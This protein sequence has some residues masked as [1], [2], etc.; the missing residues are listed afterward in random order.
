MEV[1][2]TSDDDELELDRAL[3][4]TYWMD[5]AAPPVIDR[6][7]LKTNSRE[8]RESGGA[9]ESDDELLLRRRMDVEDKNLAGIEG[10]VGKEVRMGDEMDEEVELLSSQNQSISS[11]KDTG[12]FNTTTSQVEPRPPRMESPKNPTIAYIR[13]SPKESSPPNDATFIVIPS[14]PIPTLHADSAPYI[15]DD[16]M[17]IDHGVKDQSPPQE[18]TNDTDVVEALRDIT[19]PCTA[20]PSMVT[21]A[22]EQVLQGKAQDFPVDF[23]DNTEIRSVTPTRGRRTST[24]STPRR[25]RRSQ[26]SNREQTSSLSSL[27]PPPD[28]VTTPTLASLAPLPHPEANP[29]PD[30]LARRESELQAFQRTRTFRT[31]TAIQLQPY[32]REKKIYTA[33]IR[34]GGKRLIEELLTYEHQPEGSTSQNEESFRGTGVDQDQDAEEEE[35]EIDMTV[36]P[37]VHPE[38]QDYDEYYLRY[39]EVA[40]GDDD[41]RLQ[42]ITKNRQRNEEK[43]RKVKA[44]EERQARRVEKE[45]Q[46]EIRE[47]ERMEK[48][49]KKRKK[50]EERE[51]KEHTVA[52]RKGNRGG[53]NSAH[54]ERRAN[55]AESVASDQVR[56]DV[57]DVESHTCVLIAR[58]THPQN[59]PRAKRKRKTPRSDNASDQDDLP[60]S[61]SIVIQGAQTASSRST[62]RPTTPFENFGD[63]NAEDGDSPITLSN[64]D[65]PSSA[66]QGP[67]GRRRGN[68]I[69][70]DEEET[71]DLENPLLPPVV[72]RKKGKALDRMLPAFM[73]KR[74]ANDA[75]RRFAHRRPL[76]ES[77]ISTNRPGQARPKKRV[78]PAEEE[79]DLRNFFV[80]ESGIE[81]VQP[82]NYGDHNSDIDT[83]VPYAEFTDLVSISS[84]SSSEES[85]PPSDNESI[86]DLVRGDF[87]RVLLGPQRGV[88][89]PSAPKRAHPLRQAHR[90]PSLSA[91]PQPHRSDGH[92]RQSRLDFGQITKRRRAPGKQRRSKTSH[93]RPRRIVLDDDSIFE[94]Q[95]ARE[96]DGRDMRPHRHVISGSADRA[97][98]GTPQQPGPR[99]T[100]RPPAPAPR[101]GRNSVSPTT[102]TARSEVTDSP[103]AEV[104]P[105]QI[106][107]SIKQ[108]QLDF[109]LIPLPSDVNLIGQDFPTLADF[110]RLHATPEQ[111]SFQHPE[112]IEVYGVVLH[113]SLHP[114]ELESLLP[115]LFEG[116]RKDVLGVQ[117]DIRGPMTLELS[118]RYLVEYMGSRDHIRHPSLTK[119]FLDCVNELECVL[120]AAVVP[121]QAEQMMLA[122]ALLR[123]CWAVLMLGM[124]VKTVGSETNAAPTALIERHAKLLIRKLLEY[125]FH[126]T[127]RPLK[128]IMAQQADSSEVE[129]LSVRL[130]VF[131][132]HSLGRGDLGCPSQK[133]N[134][135]TAFD[136][137][138]LSTLDDVYPK[139]QTGPMAS[140]KL[141]YLTFGVSVLKQ[142]DEDGKTGDLLE[143]KPGWPLV[144]RA[145]QTVRVRPL[146]ESTELRLRHDLKMRDRYVKIMVA[147]C[148]KMITIWQWHCDGDNFAMATRDL[149]TIFKERSHRNFPNEDAGDYPLFLSA[150]DLALTEQVDLE[151]STYNLYLRLICLTA[152]DM[153]GMA[154]SV[155]TAEHVVR[156]VQRL[157]MSIFPFSPV[158]FG[159]GSPPTNRQLAMLINRYS[160]LIVSNIFVPSLSDWLLANATK[161]LDFQQA[162]LASRN[163]IVRGVM[164]FAIA[165]RHHNTSVRSPVEQ[166]ATMFGTLMEELSA[167]ASADSRRIEIQ[168]SLVLIIGSFRHIIKHHSFEVAKQGTPSYP[169]PVL[170][171][172]CEC[173]FLRYPLC[174]LITFFSR[175][176]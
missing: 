135:S 112:N 125:G 95:E 41:E 161:W 19:E 16:G 30:P 17:D 176:D 68:V 98:A 28:E 3:Q 87:E 144:Q 71:T 75:E 153:V 133:T 66:W 105:A 96:V 2:P 91:S 93:R 111:T 157:M 48:E 81:S 160:T 73:I 37:P 97:R 117:D 35:T 63:F 39:G 123:G 171:H 138:L 129:D 126:R 62:S 124:M 26:V 56:I 23:T 85:S 115:L 79:D 52:A 169:D 9:E 139:S 173:D 18:D 145:I 132:I 168:R 127:M 116:L 172:P 55:R 5:M 40:E 33:A 102:V 141:W 100:R 130:W 175:L 162:D 90:A 143:P 113:P 99:L 49:E 164:Y 1:V 165:C 170:M 20:L 118:I 13:S 44:K 92:L 64:Q 47:R 74:L 4:Q 34:R 54:D 140:E 12:A 167:L 88:R 136:R 36:T 29:S 128:A 174:V 53:A 94:Y 42:E 121:K 134:V 70:S 51:A 106:W 147:R 120:D 58:R 152:S 10:R 108:F 148:L 150:Y 6:M 149:G 89:Q 21:P 110:Q 57:A 142:F 103:Q 60:T 104:E 50:R 83:H 84:S 114:D 24:S 7:D 163:I 45:L 146:S 65:R 14:L 82:F 27:S 80:D 61:R 101:H 59:R 151:D 156:D 38:D 67:T 122:N 69:S 119:V 131:L 22:I 158:P 86:R 72:P 137:L 159:K 43:A 107:S 109:E 31:R 155:A 25:D 15:Q 76:D 11:P 8:S 154:T 78:R 77:A 46:R 32:T 166:L